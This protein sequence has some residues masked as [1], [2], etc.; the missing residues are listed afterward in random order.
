MGFEFRHRIAFKQARTVLLISLVLGLLSTSIQIFLDLRQEKISYLAGIERVIA[1]HKKTAERA[2]YNLNY[3]KASEITAT[4]IS[5]PEISEATL[6]DDFGDPLSHDKQEISSPNTF[7]YK[8]GNYFFQFN[9]HYESILKIDNSQTGAA[10]LIIELDSTYITHNFALRAFIGLVFGLLYNVLLAC[11]FLFFFYRYLSRPILDIVKWVDQLNTHNNLPLPYKGRDEI[12]DLVASFS[13]L[14]D[15]RRQVTDRLNNTISKLSKSKNFSR[16]LMENAG[17]AMFLCAPDGTIID[18]NHQAVETLKSDKEHILGSK[19][20]VYSQNYSENDL[21]DLFLSI[22]EKHVCT[23]EDIQIDMHKKVFPIEARGI[24]IKQNDKDY[25]LISARDISARKESEKQIFELAFFDTLTG[26]AN[27]RLFTDRLS[28]VITHHQV[29]DI[30]GAVL[31]MDLDRFKTINDSLGH[32]IGDKLLC[33]VSQRLTAIAPVG[34]TCARFGGDEFVI[35]LPEIGPTVVSSAEVAV[36]ISKKIIDAIAAPFEIEG[37]TLYCTISIGIAVF[38]EKEL[39]AIDILRH[40]DIALYRTKAMGKNG[41]Q[42]YDPEV[43]SSAQ[44]R[45]LIE[46]GLH[47]ALDKGEF[48]LWFQPQVKSDGSVFGAEVLLRWMHP[49]K[50]VISPDDFI[51]IAEESGQIIE[52][53][54]WVLNESFNQLAQWRER[55]FPEGCRRL[56]INIS[57]LQFMQVDFVGRVLKLLTDYQIP[58]ELIELEITENMLLNN[59]DIASNKMRILKQRGISF[60]IDDFGTGYSSLKYLRYMPLDILKIDRSFVTNLRPSSEEAAI[61]EV[62]IATADRLGLAVVA[63]GVETVEER[64][65]LIELGCHRFQG[66]LYSKPLPAAQFYELI[67][68]TRLSV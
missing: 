58:G 43:Q 53:G 1:L 60:A 25:I 49:E 23:F 8:L 10:K 65:T 19:L 47:K 14:W 26:L 12:G 62:I 59:F 57:P 40:A 54:Q 27:R 50:G 63:E 39:S 67:S 64:D 13:K 33:A 20:S 66:Y 15:E 61:V 48:Q 9:T 30:H 52:M 28:S 36:H 32:S 3:V 51:Q 55:G 41:F 68:E 6:V 22:D 35:L 17:D 7:F 37:H 45:L 42:F 24:R 46:K 21:V 38:P 44:E 16:T 11:V 29:H 4:L 31:Y 18:L 5:H 2:I 34:T 56:A